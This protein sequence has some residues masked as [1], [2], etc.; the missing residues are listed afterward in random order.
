MCQLTTPMMEPSNNIKNAAQRYTRQNSKE[1]ESGD[2]FVVLLPPRTTTGSISCHRIPHIPSFLLSPHRTPRS[3][4]TSQ[5]LHVQLRLSGDRLF[6]WRQLDVVDFSVTLMSTMV[7]TD[8][9]MDVVNEE[10]GLEKHVMKQSSVGKTDK[11]GYVTQCLKF[12]LS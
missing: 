1:L 5:T 11:I 12:R 6:P 9:A 3:V 4:T 10:R 7:G 8:V 2:I